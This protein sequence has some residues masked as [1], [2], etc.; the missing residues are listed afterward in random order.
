MTDLC[1]YEIR[2]EDD[3]GNPQIRYTDSASRA[4]GLASQAIAN[5]A[6]YVSVLDN[7]T[8]ETVYVYDGR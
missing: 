7:Q 8:N 5:D 3:F 1:R 6:S 2:A 4:L